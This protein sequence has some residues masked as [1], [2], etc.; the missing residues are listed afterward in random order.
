MPLNQQLERYY[1]FHSRIYDATR[2]A[3]LFGRNKLV[4]E[5]LALF[6]GDQPT[7]LEIGCGTGMLLKRLLDQHENMRGIGLDLS[8]DMLNRADNKLYSYSTRYSLKQADYQQ[9]QPTTTIQGI[10][11]SYALSMMGQQAYRIIP[12]IY[13]DLEPDGYVG[14]VDFHSTPFSF[15]ERWMNFNHVSF[16]LDLRNYLNRYFDEVRYERRPAYFGLWEYVMYIGKK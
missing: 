12:K 4:T 8:A 3:F 6:S 7:V 10:I 9:Y 15:F 2:W 14:I 11:T 13:D 5:C 1:S 16:H